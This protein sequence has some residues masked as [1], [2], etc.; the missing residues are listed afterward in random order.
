[1]PQPIAY[2]PGHQYVER[3]SNRRNDVIISSF[4]E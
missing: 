1:M 4:R 3:D 2:G